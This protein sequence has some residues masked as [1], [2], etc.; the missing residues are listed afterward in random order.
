MWNVHSKQFSSQHQFE[1]L[2]LVLWSIR[3]IMHVL[4]KTNHIF[5]CS[6]KM[7]NFQISSFKVQN[8]CR[9]NKNKRF[10][11]DTWIS[12][13]ISYWIFELDAWKIFI[14]IWFTSSSSNRLSK[15]PSTYFFTEESNGASYFFT[16]KKQ[17]IL[18]WKNFKFLAFEMIHIFDGR[19]FDPAE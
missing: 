11:I 9:I 18:K 6:D 14:I 5:P 13:G 17:A 12:T 1:Y 10:Q 4:C 8:W 3:I 16:V 2:R 19:G 15:F 7:Q